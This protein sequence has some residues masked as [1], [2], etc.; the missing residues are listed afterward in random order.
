MTNALLQT[1][2]QA[3]VAQFNEIKRHKPSVVFIPNI[4]AWYECMHDTLGLRTFFALLRAIPSTDPVMVLATAET[5]L[6]HID[7]GLRFTLFAYSER[8]TL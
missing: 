8:N 2:E 5:E 3:I 6:A 1:M 4:D 7:P